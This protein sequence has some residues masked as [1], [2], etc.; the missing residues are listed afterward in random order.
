[1]TIGSESM[2]TGKGSQMITFLFPHEKQVE[3]K[4][5]NLLSL[6]CFLQRDSIMSITSLQSI[7]TED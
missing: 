3:V 4:P 6:T 1:M 2:A 7:K 5:Q